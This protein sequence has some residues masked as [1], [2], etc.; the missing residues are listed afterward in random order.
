MK[1]QNLFLLML[2]IILSSTRVDAMDDDA[3]CPRIIS[4]SP[5]ITHMLNYLGMGHC[6][7]GVSRY[8]K[9]NLP[10]TGGI[11]DPDA[12]VIASL[13]PDLFITSAWTSQSTLEKITPKDTK[14]LRLS[15]F[16]SMDQ[17]ESNMAD[18]IKLTGWDHS[19]KKV[20]DFSSQWRSKLK[21]LNGNNIKVLLLSSC[22][23]QAYSFGPDSRL[24][25]L[26]SQAGFDV[27]ETGKKIRHIQPGQE[28]ESLNTLL[29]RYQPN[30]LFVFEQKMKKRC[31]LLTPKLPVRILTL[32]GRQ[33]LHPTTEILDGLDSLSKKKH[34]WQ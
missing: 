25:D 31:Q 13:D 1:A 23:G 34:Y 6:I 26:F 18:V 29:D 33:F 3:P 30:L 5:Y 7:V 14:S 11:L 4:Q 12:E 16:N 8:S 22:S 2:V 24:Y 15:S 20:D 9:L 27:V 21:L 17:L 10:R 32:N 19:Q 28:I